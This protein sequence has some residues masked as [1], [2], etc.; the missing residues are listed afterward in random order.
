[1][2][3]REFMKMLSISI[4][5]DRTIIIMSISI[6]QPSLKRTRQTKIGCKIKEGILI[7][8]ANAFGAILRAIIDNQKINA[9]SLRAHGVNRSF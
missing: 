6:F 2:N 5:L 3:K 4:E 1:M 8:S 9:R 7:F